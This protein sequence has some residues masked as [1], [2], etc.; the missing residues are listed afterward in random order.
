MKLKSV[1]I[2]Y[3][4]KKR[5]SNFVKSYFFPAPLDYWM[6]FTVTFININFKQKIVKDRHDM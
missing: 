4:L 5:G 1:Y 6:L 3:C 2:F